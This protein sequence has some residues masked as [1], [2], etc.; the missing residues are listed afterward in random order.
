MR[1]TAFIRLSISLAVVGLL[2]PAPAL[3]QGDTSATGY[4]LSSAKTLAILGGSPSRLA[5]IMAKQ[6]GMPQSASLRPATMPTRRTSYAV[7]DRAV[8]HAAPPRRDQPDIFGSVALAVRRTS[9]DYRWRKV[10][11]AAVS[12]SSARYAKALRSLDHSER[13]NRVNRYVN[14]RVAFIDDILQF[15]EADR[16]LSANETL[17]RGRGDC[18]DYAIA[19][20]QLLR[21][22]G[23]PASDMYVAVVKDLVRRA[24]HAI[25]VVRS[26]DGRMLV[27]DNG[28]DV[29]ADA[30]SMRDYRPVLTFA[31]TSSWTHGYRQTAAPLSAGAV[32]MAALKPAAAPSAD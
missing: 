4:A 5:V 26:G 9:L 21:A 11:H 6:Q 19:K 3:A 23:I 7:L 29:I 17:R 18:E 25:L 14:G 16:W 28:S 22:A 31:A 10:S 32:S 15:G 12:G 2:A 27:L 13:I 24:D 20:Y 30:N 8:A 1:T